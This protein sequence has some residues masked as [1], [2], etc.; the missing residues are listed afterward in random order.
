[1]TP[2]EVST[3]ASIATGT[4]L[5]GARERRKVGLRELARTLGLHPSAMSN[6]ELGTTAPNRRLSHVFLAAF[7]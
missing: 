5:R 1:M 7:A 2:T 6:L 3:P 4:G